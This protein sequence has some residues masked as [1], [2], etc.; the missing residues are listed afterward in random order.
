MN[1]E[2]IVYL[3]AEVLEKPYEEINSLSDNTQLS[4]IGLDSIRFIQ[5]IVRLEETQN[6]E[7]LDSDLLLP[8]FGT[9]NSIFATMRKYETPLKKALVL[10]CDGVLWHGIAGE[11][12]ITVDDRILAFQNVVKQL[13][14][15]GV[16]LCLCSRNK[17]ENL[18][19]AFSELAIPLQLEDFVVIHTDTA[20]KTGSLRKIAAELNIFPDSLVFADDSDYELGLV[21]A[22]LPKIGTVKVDFDNPE[23][24]NELEFLFQLLPAT[25]L[26]RM[27]LYC[28]QKEREK[29]KFVCK[30]PEEY[31][32]SLQTVLQ[33]GK[34]KKNELPR[35]SEL[36]QRTN[37]CN[38]SA[39]RYTEPELADLYQKEDVE[40]L[41][42]F[43]SDRYGDMGLVGAAVLHINETSTTIESFFLSC[44][45]F[46]RGFEQSLLEY[47]KQLA[48]KKLLIG[49]FRKT[50]QNSKYEEF[51]PKNE[52]KVLC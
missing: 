6:I 39:R 37:R 36:S 7:V 16:L 42:L 46:D 8:N 28:E 17:M 1:R 50:P 45:V 2:K 33:C 5:F 44:R 9:I 19:E 12:Q 40:I 23:L 10:D 4:E 32:E 15:K 13:A 26:D 18:T 24:G 49:I 30:T 25:E 11:E 34:A 31:N 27:R 21:R 52:V 3:L 22:L 41:S 35:I 38:L 51:Y 47:I 48:G 29:A 43:A 14:Q 20:E